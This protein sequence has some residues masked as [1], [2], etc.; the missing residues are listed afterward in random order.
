MDADELTALADEKGAFWW[1]A[2]G[3]VEQG[4]ILALTGNASEAVHMLTSGITALRS[5]GATVSLPSHLSHL[6]RAYAELGQFDDAWRCIGEAMSAVAT[7]KERWFEAEV[8]PTAGEIALLSPEP[9][10]TKAE[11]YFERA[12]AVARQQQAKSWELRAAG[13]LARLWRD[14]GQASKRANC[15]LW[16]TA[17]LWRV[18][19]AR[20]EGGEGVA[21]GVG[22]HY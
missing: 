1:K 8:H 7:T 2:L 13:S 3:M 9:D 12:L 17:G 15:W 11:A 22:G 20:F 5:T 10:V 14:Q 19:D 18:R 4:G 6:A 21:G 16:F